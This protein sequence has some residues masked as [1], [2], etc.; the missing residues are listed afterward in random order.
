MSTETAIWKAG[1]CQASLSRRAIV[2][3]VLVSGT[4]STAPGADLG[5]AATEAD[6]AG[7]VAPDDAARSMSSATILPSGPVPANPFSSSPRSRASL[8]ASGEAFVRS[9][10]SELSSVSIVET[11]ATGSNTSAG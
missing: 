10:A 1:A 2:R 3:L 7:A 11:E 8:R 6:A 9:P 4:R 5:V